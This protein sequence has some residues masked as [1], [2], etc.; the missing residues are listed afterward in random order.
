VFDFG[1]N[2]PEVKTLKGNEDL[3]KKIAKRARRIFTAT[4]G[5]DEAL[6]S[7]SC[8]TWAACGFAAAAE[9]GVQLLPQAGTALWRFREPENESDP[10]DYALWL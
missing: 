2:F 10:E 3:K 8:L 6:M 9:N 4:Y 7:S 1:E 5:D